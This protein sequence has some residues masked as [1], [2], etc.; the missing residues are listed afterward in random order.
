MD[1]RSTLIEI[2]KN[3]EWNLI[4]VVIYTTS[5]PFRYQELADKYRVSVIRM[6][7]SPAEI[8]NSIKQILS[9]CRN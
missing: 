1:G 7:A 9:H 4:P 6:P 5:L 8:R 3:P 2:K